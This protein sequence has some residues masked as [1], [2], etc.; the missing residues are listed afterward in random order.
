MNL[1]P[2]TPKSVVFLIN[3]SRVHLVLVSLENL[4]PI[5]AYFILQQ[6]RQV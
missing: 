1:D 5:R 2:L 4:L 3:Y 6:C